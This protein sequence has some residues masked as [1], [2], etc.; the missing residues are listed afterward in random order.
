MSLM[1]TRPWK[2]PKTGIYYL[3]RAVPADL[4]ALI[5]K[6][7]EKISLGTKDPVRAKSLHA[8]ALLELDERWTNLRAGR[9]LLS[10]REAHEMVEP[11]YAWWIDQ[12]RDEPS[13]QAFWRIYLG[14]NLWPRRLSGWSLQSNLAATLIKEAA[15]PSVGARRDMEEWCTDQADAVLKQRGIVVDKSNRRKLARAP[16]ACRARLSSIRADCAG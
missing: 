15:D 5:G 14:E 11:L 4:L 1:T 3:R 9:K 13:Q 6:R 12:H 2:H 7:E 10:E 16:A 8:R